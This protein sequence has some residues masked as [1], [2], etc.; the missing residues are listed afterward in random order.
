MERRVGEGFFNIFTKVFFV[1]ISSFSC[2]WL[3]QNIDIFVLLRD[4]S[5]VIKTLNHQNI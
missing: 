2:A 3:D 4:G 5:I 1:Y